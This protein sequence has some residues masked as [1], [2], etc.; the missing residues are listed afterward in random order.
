MYAVKNVPLNL[1]VLIY[2]KYGL[3]ACCLSCYT[4]TFQCNPTKL[5]LAKYDFSWLID[6][7]PTNLKTMTNYP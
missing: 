2:N 7:T 3:C 5:T 1:K 4:L 6:T